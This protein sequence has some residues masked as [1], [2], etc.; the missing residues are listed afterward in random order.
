MSSDIAQRLVRGSIWSLVG[1]TVSRL[2]MLA[3][4]ILL[5]RILGQTQFGEF[6][7]VQSTL[8]VA[9]M[10]AGFG[11]GGAATRF[12]A[13]YVRS[14]PERAGRI[15]VLV[16]RFSWGVVL[17]VGVLV[18]LFSGVIA[19]EVLHAS[20]LQTP[21]IW[22][23]L[24]MMAMA[25][26]GVQ[27]AVLAGL[28]RFD[29]IAKLNM[30][31][32]IVSVLGLTLFA[33]FL[34]IEGGLIGL[35][36]GMLIAWY[37]GRLTLRRILSDLGVPVSPKGSW[38]E[39]NILGNYSLPSFI[40]SSVASP[41]LW[42]CMTLVAKRPN[43]Y[44]HLALYNAAYQWHGPLIF[45]PMILLSVST[46]VLV[47]QWESRSLEKF[48]KVLFW[49][50]GFLLAV[51]A[52]PVFAIAL[53]GKRIMGLYGP[54]FESGWIVLLLLASA[55]PIHVLS[56]MAATAL[57]SMN[58]AWHVAKLNVI[59]GIAMLSLAV[60]LIPTNGVV[61][62]AIAFTSA[63]LIQMISSITLVLWYMR[64]ETNNERNADI[65]MSSEP[66]SGKP[67]VL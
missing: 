52:L 16:T 60:M 67:H 66:E 17:L 13:Q 19:R 54:G 20:Q 39:R 64:L 57:F 56:K 12:V 24:L 63:Y 65:L 40:A 9:G 45:V 15:I 35:A 32:G 33:W 48:R 18:S 46:P 47:Q 31:E 43:G 11:L 50:A 30:L 6:G 34:G 59:W 44:D 3:G 10:L 14:D 28:E 27:S 42:Y 55:A 21:L 29:V 38:Q 5:A 22:G 62:L 23:A 1:S 53:M 8:G 26:R 4:M 58:Y 37:T 25:I 51:S 49:N 41:V 36:I 7:M 2:L 61:G